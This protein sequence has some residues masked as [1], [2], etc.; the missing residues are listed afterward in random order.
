MFFSLWL[1]L[2]LDDS[3]KAMNSSSIHCP[4][5]VIQYLTPAILKPGERNTET[6]DGF[7]E[8]YF[9]HEWAEYDDFP[10]SED[11]SV[12]LADLEW[13]ALGKEDRQTI[14]SLH[15]MATQIAALKD[16]VSEMTRASNAEDFTELSDFP[17]SEDLDAFLADM[18]LDCE[19]IP[20]RTSPTFRSTVTSAAFLNSKP[21]GKIE[22]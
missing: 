6:V 15:S 13:D 3:D 5:G 14:P 16:V 4:P 2:D 20:M 11:L 9:L 19:N 7:T 18:E 8:E 1:P 17:S 22:G 21:N 12:F 10:S